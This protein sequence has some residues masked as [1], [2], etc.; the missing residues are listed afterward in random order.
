[1]KI[2]WRSFICLIVCV[3]VQVAL[4]RYVTFF[5]DVI[6]LFVVFTGIFRGGTEAAVSGFLAGF[7]RGCFSV[8]TSALDIF[9]FPAV[10][11]LS[12]ALGGKVY[13]QNPVAQIFI[14]A[15][16]VVTVVIA[17]TIYLNVMTGSGI[18]IGFVFLNSWKTLVAT[19]LV[20]PFFFVFLK[21][22]LGLGE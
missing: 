8:G 21:G 14:A 6:L 17:H 13:R 22:A 9:L 15:I 4:M 7:L 10:G 11:I 5:P 1:M 16:A 19:V 3:L 12:S 2:R 20:A 18:G